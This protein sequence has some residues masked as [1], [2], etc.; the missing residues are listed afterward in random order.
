[1]TPQPAGDER[2]G[3]VVA[4]PGSTP[5]LRMAAVG[6]SRFGLLHSYVTPFAWSR[7]PSWASAMP[8]RAGAAV[9]RELSKRM[10]PETVQPIRRRA[11]VFEGPAVLAR[12]LSL[13]RLCTQL[14]E[15]RN[16]AFDRQLSRL[17]RPSHSALVARPGAALRSLQRAKE[18]R[19]TSY[20]LMSTVHHRFAE[21]LLTEEANLQ[22]DFAETLQFHRFGGREAARLDAEIASADRLLALSPLVERSCRESGVSGSKVDQLPLGVDVELFRPRAAPRRTAFRVIFVGQITQRKG[23]SYL[24]EGF[25]RAALPDCELLLVGRV[26]GSDRPWRSFPGVRH[27]NPVPRSQL[28]A[29]YGSA[30]VFAMPSLIEGF[31]LTALEAMACGLPPIVSE[32]VPAGGITDG[33]DGYVV[34]IRDADAIADRL[35]HLAEHPAER[36]AMAEAARVRA[37]DFTWERYW[38]RLAT[39]V[40]PTD[41]GLASALDRVGSS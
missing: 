14:N 30:D 23:L 31:C 5:S 20:L 37:L 34:P 10:V 4:D 17:L 13:Q 39:L 21:R 29:L 3:V 15:R 26:V 7:T 11:A 36:A 1:M 12:R 28:P 18:L 6:L 24:L 40:G 2:S 8:G 9:R 27:L 19:V 25:R 22:P 38:E 41:S 16:A 35:V 33:H 32:H